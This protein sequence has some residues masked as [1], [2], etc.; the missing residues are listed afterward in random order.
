MKHLHF[1][2]LTLFC[3]AS[4]CSYLPENTADI[5]G[6]D[7]R[8]ERSHYVLSPAEGSPTKK[9]AMVFYPGGLVDPAAYIPA[10]AQLVKSDQRIVVVLKAT[11]N[12]AIMNPNLAAKV[13]DEE[14]DLADN[15]LIA[16]H[17]LGGVVAAMATER[18]PD[19]FVALIMQAAYSS[20]D[21]SQWP[22]PMMIITGSEDE[23]F[24]SNDIDANQENMLP[25]NFLESLDDLT[26]TGTIGQTIVW[27]IE[28]GNHGQFGAYGFQEGDGEAQISGQEQHTQV[29]NA[30]KAFLQSNNIE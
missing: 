3:L 9:T 6:V 23:V 15:W 26:E 24:E 7:I 4:S 20:V 1:L 8:E 29:A 11:G 2:L 21:L 13:V 18:N 27:E 10:L 25:L 5:D 30:I 14:N 12:L 19:L 22:N 16:G 17:S 28:G